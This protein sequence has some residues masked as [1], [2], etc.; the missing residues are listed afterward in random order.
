MSPGTSSSDQ[1]PNPFYGQITT[2]ALAQPT[3]QARNIS[4]GRFPEFNGVVANAASWGNSNYHALQARFE[5]RYSRGLSLLVAYTWSKTISD[6][7]DGFWAG[8]WGNMRNWYCRACDRAISVYDQPHRFVLN[9]TYE[10]PFGRGK[11][12]ARQ[13]EPPD[14][15][16]PGGWQVNGIL[17]LSVGQPI[18][19]YTAQNTSF[20]TAGGANGRI[21]PGLVPTSGCAHHCPMVRYEPDCPAPAVYVRKHGAELGCA[22]R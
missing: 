3:V 1:A 19:F 21:P 11:A 16:S 17:T 5:K 18:I 7:V 15:W 14:R 13:M 22:L 2:G 9:S 6:G 20:R 8:P 10:L 12:F 4:P